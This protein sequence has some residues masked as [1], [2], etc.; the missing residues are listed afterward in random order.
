M[1]G[2]VPRETSLERDGFH[3]SVGA[4]PGP[5]D[6]VDQAGCVHLDAD[7]RLEYIE[8]FS[9]L[10]FLF[11]KV[12]DVAGHL[13]ETLRV[14]FNTLLDTLDDLEDVLKSCGVLIYIT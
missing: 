4:E 7:G 10:S 3:I 6:G 8:P 5:Y 12:L 9:K 11:N 1:E 2:H 14:V 13:L